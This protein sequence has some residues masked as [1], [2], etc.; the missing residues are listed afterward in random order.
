MELKLNHKSGKVTFSLEK[1]C[2]MHD[3]EFDFELEALK[4][5][6]DAVFAISVY[7]TDG[8]W[9]IGQTSREAGVAWKAMATGECARGRLVLEKNLLAPGDY[10]VAFGAY[11][12]DLSI[13]YALTEL[14]V[15][16]SVRTDF[17]TWGKVLHPARWI[18]QSSKP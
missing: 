9:V 8:D 3:I 13:C 16:F 5:L 4:P 11:S 7:R 14:N 6:D 2:E 10:A 12:A 1:D 18:I 15:H 17:P